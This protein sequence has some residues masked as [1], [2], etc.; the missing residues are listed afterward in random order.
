MNSKYS[1]LYAALAGGVVQVL[2]SLF[3]ASNGYTIAAVALLT[4][5]GVYQVS[6]K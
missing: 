5:L 6:N 1:K 3:G 2:V 4:A